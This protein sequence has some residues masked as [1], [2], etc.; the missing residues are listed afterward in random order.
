M[1]IIL[2]LSCKNNENN[3][4]DN[5]IIPKP[6]EDNF[7]TGELTVYNEIYLIINEN[8]EGA[9]K[10]KNYVM[11]FLSK[12]YHIDDVPEKQQYGTNIFLTYNIFSIWFCQ[13][14]NIER[15]CMVKK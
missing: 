6:L 3:S 8:S 11:G 13:N 10:L 12:S 7:E 1:G 9:T 5:N 15:S 2:F 4:F 14:G